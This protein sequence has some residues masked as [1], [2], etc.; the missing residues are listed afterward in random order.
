MAE[1]SSVARR[2]VVMEADDALL[3]DLPALIE[4]RLPHVV[5]DARPAPHPVHA[6]LGADRPAVLLVGIPIPGVPWNR[7]IADAKTFLPDV[8]VVLL[9]E[10]VD[11]GLVEAA[12]SA[13]AFEVVP[14][15]FDR[16]DFLLTVRLALQANR[17]AR[18]LRA[19]RLI[20][21]RVNARIRA[22]AEGL[23]SQP[24][25]SPDLRMG[26]PYTGG[27]TACHRTAYHNL[28]AAEQR[29]CASA[30]QLQNAYAAGKQRSWKRI[31]GL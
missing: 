20:V 1:D 22:L 25:E 19:R 21:E 29:L 8:S 27:V 4:D 15:P 17:L 16:Y 2:I 28:R 18:F 10:Q 9:A 12:T 23:G 24:G 13:G 5:V 14:K 7:I 30:E 26:R 11:G 3:E 6:E 31:L